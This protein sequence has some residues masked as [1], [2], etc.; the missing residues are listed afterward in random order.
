MRELLEEYGGTLLF[1]LVGAGIITIF[2]KLLEY[3]SY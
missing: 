3:L 1:L 2:M